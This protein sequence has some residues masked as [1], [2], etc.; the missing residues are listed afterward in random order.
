MMIVNDD[1]DNDDCRFIIVPKS[2]QLPLFNPAFIDYGYNK[3]EWL[4]HLRLLGYRF[5]VLSH[6][7]AFHVK[8]E[9]YVK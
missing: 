9:K 8:H 3:I 5:S 6:S 1:D 4:T 7:W 2:S